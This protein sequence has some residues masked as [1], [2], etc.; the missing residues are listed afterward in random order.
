MGMQW[1]THGFWLRIHICLISV[2]GI[3]ECWSINNEGMALLEFRTRITYD[4]YNALAHWNPNDFDPCKWVGVHCVDGKVKML[5]LNGLSLEGTLAPQLGKLSHLKYLV[6]CKNKFSGVIPKELGDLA[7]LELLDL[8]EN[9]LSGNIPEEIDKL[10]LLKYLLLCDNKI[11]GSDF[12]Y[13]RKFKMSSKLLLV[14]N[15]SSP[16]TTLFGC[17]NRKFV[18]CVWQGNSKQGNKLD[19]LIIPI[20]AT[21]MKYFNAFARP[22]FKLENP[23]F[24]GHEDNYCDLLSSSNVLEIS[25]LPNIVN[26]ARRKLLD[27]SSN[28]AAT[29]F[30]GGPTI[31]FS[32]IPTTISSGSFPAVPNDIKKQKQ[33]P[34]PSDSPRDAFDENQTNQQQLDKGSPGKFW[35][36][37]TIVIFVVVLSL[38]IMVFFCIWRKR[39]AKVINPWKSGISGQLRK[40]FITGVPKLNRSELEIACED[41]SN[42]IISYEGCT[43]YKGT[44]SS[45][46]EIAVVSTLITSSKDWSKNSEINYRKKIDTLSRVN[47]KNF[48]NLIGYCVEEKPFTRMLVF[49]YAPNGT[50]FE[51]LHVQEMERLDWSERTRIIMGIAYCLQ[52]MHHDLSPPLAHYN[53]SSNM[54]FLTDDFAAKAAEVTFRDIVSSSKIVR[55]DSKKPKLFETDFQKNVYD[56]GVLL[57]E[58]ISGKLCD[59]E[60]QGNLVNWGVKYLN[61]KRSCMIDP[62]LLSFNEN[63]LDVIC[64]VIQECIQPDP[65][66][67][68]TMR[69]ITSKLREVIGVSPEQAVPRLSPLWWAE[70]EI[71]SVEAT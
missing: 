65:K 59:D 37:I 13:H 32:S 56:F 63:E 44:L 43:I 47:H 35:N 36:Y 67:R 45:G 50:I 15:C 23:T 4:P 11:E 9:D 5:K 34:P 49:E 22:I 2:W 33:S 46:V 8:R 69:H 70:L 14:Q 26:F 41:F 38:V 58:I 52:Y 28:L 27:Q 62:T 1:N 57:L 68:P 60:E 24:H 17:T 31:E 29:T 53:L 51:H 10:L 30:S 25:N 42:I 48:V 64:E 12:Q 66:L 61:D 16:L 21:L 19:S 39:P 71:L 55:G 20:K 54:I 6:L 7:K 18:P 3:Q 40:A